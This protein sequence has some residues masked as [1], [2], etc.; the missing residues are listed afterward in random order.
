[1]SGTRGDAR[2]E[3][4]DAIVA[5]AAAFEAVPFA[6]IIEQQLPAALGALRV[7]RHPFE[8]GAIRLAPGLVFVLLPPDEELVR[9]PVLD[10]IEEDAR[11][12]VAVASGPPRFLVVGLQRSGEVVVHD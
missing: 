9:A 10:A 11:R 2:F 12:R 8:L 3:R 6:E 7:A 4:S 1:T 5:N